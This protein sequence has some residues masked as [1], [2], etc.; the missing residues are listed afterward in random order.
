M[1]GVRERD[2]FE[3]RRLAEAA[4]WRTHLT[5]AGENSI[6][7]ERWLATDPA[8]EAAWRQVQGPWELFGEQ[9]T[10]PALIEAR[11]AALGR[12]R[13]AAHRQHGRRGV[14]GKIA[15]A[16]ALIAVGAGLI[17]SLQQPQVYRTELGERRVV[18]LRD[19][20]QLSLDS[21]TEV[22]VRYSED[23]RSLTLVQGQARFDVARDVERPFAVSAGGQKI[24]ATGTAFN[25]DLMGVNLLVTLIEG[26]VVVLDEHPEA[27]RKRGSPGNVETPRPVELQ[28]GQQLMLAPSKPPEITPASI[29]R[30][31]AWQSGRLVFEDELLSSVTA[32]VS[33][34]TATTLQ[35]TDERAATLRISGVFTTGDING[36]VDTV[37]EYLPV[38]AERGEGGAIALVY[39]AD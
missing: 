1:T 31:T 19:G 34:Y 24:V 20:S 26:R 18:T 36:F 35:V 5:E 30:A 33:R 29:E 12:A 7:F 37:T 25:V 2:E 4:A 15:A 9:A 32:R 3:G 10:A 22:R 28:A 21:Q 14:F 6:E 23:A 11:R 13:M 38:R 8:N 39:R 16:V 17:W 27:E